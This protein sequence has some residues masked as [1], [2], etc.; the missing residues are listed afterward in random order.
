MK[1]PF[2]FDRTEESVEDKAGTGTLTALIGVLGLMLAA[3]LY[4]LA[5]A[6]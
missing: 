1:T 2:R 4:A 6:I 3:I 5:R